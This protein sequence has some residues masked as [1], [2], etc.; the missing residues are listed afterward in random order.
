MFHDCLKVLN[1]RLGATVVKDGGDFPDEEFFN[2]VVADHLDH[3]S[4]KN[5]PSVVVVDLA[6]INNVCFIADVVCQEESFEYPLVLVVRAEHP[7]EVQCND[8]NE[9][10]RKGYVGGESSAEGFSNTEDET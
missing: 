3:N 10:D 5:D 7:N 9:C 4:A 1:L 2:D 6:W 8:D